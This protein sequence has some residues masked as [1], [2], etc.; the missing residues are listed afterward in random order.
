M[1]VLAGSAIA[2]V[3]YGLL[4]TTPLHHSMLYR[5]SC[6]NPLAIA[7]VWLFSIGAVSLATKWTT[8]I[9]QQTRTLHASDALEELIQLLPSDDL[10]S[11]SWLETTWKCQST[12]MTSSWFGRRTS[13]WLA[14]QC[15]RGPASNGES[16]LVELADRDR[17]CQRQG[18]GLHRALVVVIPILGL[19]GSVLEI[20]T[21][22]G[23]LD[24]PGTVG[25]SP[26]W[27]SMAHALAAAMNT[28]MVSLV[29]TIGL[30]VLQHGTARS[31]EQLLR[32]MDTLASEHL[33]ACFPERKAS[34]LADH[35]ETT[36]AE[37][38]QAMTTSVQQVVRTQAE[39]WKETVSQAHAQWSTLTDRSM[40][41]IQ[42]ALRQAIE[43]AMAAHREGLT[44]HVQQLSQIQHDGAILIDAR[45]QQWQTTLSEQAR[46]TYQHQREIHAQSELLR[47]L[48]EKS[49]AIRSLDQS[50]QGTLGRLTDVDRFHE[51]AICLTEAVAVLGIQM[52]RNGV[53]G[54]QTARRRTPTT[55]IVDSPTESEPDTIPLKRRAG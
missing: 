34:P 11:R 26:N 28:T 33:L 12:E 42:D 47:D 29:L 36:L 16:D 55:P 44:R 5:Y 32:A 53:L 19:L 7:I 30:I 10:E 43:Q 40:A 21:A 23:T 27:P 52:E 39:L 13:R 51:A 31:E 15:K 25:S 8:A 24:L 46:A 37:V 50:L 18:Y 38:A 35:S 20:S 3:Y 1:A 17:Q 4:L 14:R 48:L 22:I 6:S 49:D 9:K 2:M 45:W 41:T 54:R